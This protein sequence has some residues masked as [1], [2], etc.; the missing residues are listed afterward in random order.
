M[1]EGQVFLRDMSPAR[2][3]VAGDVW[4]LSRRLFE[5]IVFREE[6]DR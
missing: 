5:G 3:S 4:F 6:I 2:G 1:N